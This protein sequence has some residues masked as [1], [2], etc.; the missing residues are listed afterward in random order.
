MLLPYSGK[1]PAET[2]AEATGDAAKRER[3]AFVF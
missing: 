2:A 1:R 3:R